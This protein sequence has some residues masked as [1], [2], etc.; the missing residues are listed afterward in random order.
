MFQPPV[1]LPKNKTTWLQTSR[2]R[3]FSVHL[4]DSNSMA[5]RIKTR[6][7]KTV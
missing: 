2:S 4:N 7:F 1:F 6:V 3:L 5:S